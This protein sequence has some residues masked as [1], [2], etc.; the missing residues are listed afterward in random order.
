MTDWVKSALRFAASLVVSTLIASIALAGEPPK[1]PPTPAAHRDGSHDFDF[2]FGVWTTELK[3]LQSPLSGSTTWIDYRGTTTVRPILG[4]RANLAE[5][6]VEGAAG[7]I[8]GAALRLYDP[9]A[10]QWSLNYFNVSDGH[11][12]PPV[13]GE[14]SNER[15]VF[16]AQDTFRGRAILVRFVIT[17]VDTDTYRFEQAFSTDGG[18]HWELNWIATDRRNK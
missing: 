16:F 18:A 12:T 14:F 7:R 17:K 8:E 1:S 2:E 11:L 13:I 15:G 3:R 5:L 6:V 9:E 4:G 10:R